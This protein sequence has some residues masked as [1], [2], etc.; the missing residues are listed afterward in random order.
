M[1]EQKERKG[2]RRRGPPSETMSLYL[3]KELVKWVENRATQQSEVKQQKVYFK[4]VVSEVLR[5]FATDDGDPSVKISVVMKALA[6][7]TTGKQVIS[8]EQYDHIETL[9]LNNIK[10]LLMMRSYPLPFVRNNPQWVKA[11]ADREYELVESMRLFMGYDDPEAAR[12]IVG[13]LI[14]EH[15]EEE[16]EA[17]RLV[18]EQ[19]RSDKVEPELAPRPASKR[20]ISGLLSLFRRFAS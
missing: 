19:S 6:D 14:R 17:I 13:A 18:L 10:L 7:K 1:T 3:D 4:D 15:E 20:G 11:C 12:E 16:V 2:G 5:H 9:V 8:Q